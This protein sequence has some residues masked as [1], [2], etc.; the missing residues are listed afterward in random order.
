MTQRDRAAVAVD[1]IRIQPQLSYAGDGL[2]G[3]RFIEFHCAEVF[4][5]PAG[6]LKHFPG[7]GHRP[8]AH[9]LGSD[10][11]RGSL[12]DSGAGP[13]PVLLCRPFRHH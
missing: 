13:K 12:D 3:K 9:D 10:S 4:N 7:G 1:H 2:A 5:R 6:A 8:N 11:H